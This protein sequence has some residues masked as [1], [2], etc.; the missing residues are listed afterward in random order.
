VVTFNIRYSTYSTWGDVLFSKWVGDFSTWGTFSTWGDVSFSKKFWHEVPCSFQNEVV[1]F[2]YEVSLYMR[3]WDALFSKWGGDFDMRYLFDMH[4]V[5][6]FIM[7]WWL[8]TWGGDFL[9][10]WW[11]NM[12]WSL[13][14]MRWSLF[15]IRWYLSTCGNILFQNEVLFQQE[16]VPFQHEIKMRATQYNIILC[17]LHLT[18]W[19]MISGL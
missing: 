1:A 2:Q 7:G 16:E 15:N 13:F 3:V 10:E 14:N 6:T 12:R 17:I 18:P 9:Q 4:E 19:Y 5:V 11:L 8:L